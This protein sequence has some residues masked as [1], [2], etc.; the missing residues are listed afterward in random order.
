LSARGNCSSSEGVSVSE[1]EEVEAFREGE[2]GRLDAELFFDCMPTSCPF[3]EDCNGYG[4]NLP[5]RGAFWLNAFLAYSSVSFARRSNCCCS[6][7][8]RVSEAEDIEGL[9]EDEVAD[10]GRSPSMYSKATA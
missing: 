7:A 8:V 3:R 10:S 2:A 5:I 1:I 9:R 6:D 4:V